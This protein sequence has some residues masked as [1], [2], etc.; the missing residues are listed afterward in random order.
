MDVHWVE[1]KAIWFARSPALHGNLGGGTPSQQANGD[2]PLD[3]VVLSR[4]GRL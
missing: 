2:V 1:E 3:G 4:L